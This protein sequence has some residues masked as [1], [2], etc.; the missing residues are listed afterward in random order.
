MSEPNKYNGKEIKCTKTASEELWQEKKDIWF[1]V[2][3]LDIGYDCSRSKRSSNIIEK[4]VTRGNKVYKAVILDC[5]AYYLLIHFGIFTYK[6][7]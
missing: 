7:R 4:C 6:R 2:G 5:V 3:I 1:V